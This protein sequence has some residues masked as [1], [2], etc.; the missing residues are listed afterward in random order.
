MSPALADG[1]FTTEPPGKPHPLTFLSRKICYF[2]LFLVQQRNSSSLFI[3][4][5]PA[6]S[7]L[8]KP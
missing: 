5:V 3:Y 1:F 7:I 6:H 2:L 8:I 4:P